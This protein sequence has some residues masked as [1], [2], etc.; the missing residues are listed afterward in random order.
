[1]HDFEIEIMPDIRA[2]WT[3]NATLFNR[4]KKAWL[5]KILGEDWAWPGGGDAGLVEQEGD[6]RLLRQALRRAFRHADGRAA[7]C[8]WPPG[9]RR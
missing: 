2:H 9:A 4:F 6:R 7:R 3:P 5:L 8:R 1:M